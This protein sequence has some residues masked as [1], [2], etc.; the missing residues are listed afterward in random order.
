[1]L[2]RFESPNGQFRLSVEP[3][4]TFSSLTSK[5]G[6][7]PKGGPVHRLDHQTA[8]KDRQILDHLPPKTD[9]S[10]IT[11]SNKPIGHSAGEE[12]L[13]NSLHGI[14]MHQVGLS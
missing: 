4:D 9:A 10:T 7:N 14:K 2:L 1:M 3:N 6:F 11:L 5:V 12:R 13:L 8:N